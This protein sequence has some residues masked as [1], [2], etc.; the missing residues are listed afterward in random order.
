MGCGG[1]G[2][3]GGRIQEG[4]GIQVGGEAPTGQPVSGHLPTGP[5]ELSPGGSW[6]CRRRALDSQPAQGASVGRPYPTRCHVL[7]Q[8]TTAGTTFWRP[9][10]AQ[11][12]VTSSLYC[13]SK[14]RGGPTCSVGRLR[15]ERPCVPK[16]ASLV[17]TAKAGGGDGS[18]S[19]LYPGLTCGDREG[20]RKASAGHRPSPV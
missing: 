17:G 1:S 19:G 9:A 10:P 2:I 11:K 7:A 20:R 15:P 13:P 16:S 12:P 3:P 4:G 8:G 18:Q 6:L 14:A 5:G